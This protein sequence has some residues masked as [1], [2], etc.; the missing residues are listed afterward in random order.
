MQWPSDL[1]NMERW[2]VRERV[3]AVELFIRTGSNTETQHG[4]HCEWNQQ[5]APSPNV[6]HRWVRQWCE[7]Y[8]TCK[9]PPVRPSWVRTPD[10]IAQALVSIS[11]SP[12]QFAHKHAQ[13]LRMSDRNVRRILHSDLRLHSCKL[14]VVH[15]L[16][17]RDREMRLQFCLQFEGNIDWKSRPAEQTSDEWRGTFSFAWHS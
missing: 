1:V 6:I 9:K 15:A 17:N 7:D 13:A 5:E 10:D 4:F 16:S 11:R 14:Q 3:C 2:G 12:R 8:V